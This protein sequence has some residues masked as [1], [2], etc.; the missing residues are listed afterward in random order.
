MPRTIDT[1]DNW[2]IEQEAIGANET[3]EQITAT[4]DDTDVKIVVKEQPNGVQLQLRTP[5]NLPGGYDTAH[6]DDDM[7]SV[8]TAV[9]E[10]ERYVAMHDAEGTWLIEGAPVPN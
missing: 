8:G 1:S 3:R 10:L 6:E 9:S 7:R 5:A 2:S 4:H